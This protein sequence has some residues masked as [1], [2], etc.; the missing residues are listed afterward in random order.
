MN[1]IWKKF[2]DYIRLKKDREFS[3]NTSIRL[4]HGMNKISIIMFLI[5]IVVLVV[6]CLH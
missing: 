6:R 5:A 3:S 2:L 1:E 4:M